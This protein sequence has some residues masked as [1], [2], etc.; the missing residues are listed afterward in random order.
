[1]DPTPTTTAEYED[2]SSL[3]AE[4]LDGETHTLDTA[5]GRIQKFN[6]NQTA[7]V[8]TFANVGE[9][10]D[11]LMAKN[12]KKIASIIDDHESLATPPRSPILSKTN[13]Q[14]VV[15]EVL[16]NATI[17]DQFVNEYLNNPTPPVSWSAIPATNQTVVEYGTPTASVDIVELIENLYLSKK[18][19]ISSLNQ[20][21]QKVVYAERKR[22][23]AAEKAATRGVTAPGAP[24]WSPSILQETH[25]DINIPQI[26][27][28]LNFAKSNKRSGSAYSFDKK[29]FPVR[30][31]KDV[32]TGAEKYF[33]CIQDENGVVSE[34]EHPNPTTL[35][36]DIMNQTKKV[37]EKKDVAEAVDM[38]KEFDK[39]KFLSLCGAVS[40]SKELRWEYVLNGQKF[41]IKDIGDKSA[42][43]PE[44]KYQVEFPWEEHGHTKKLDAKGSAEE[45]MKEISENIHIHTEWDH[46]FSKIGFVA[47]MHH[48]DK[49]SKN[50]PKEFDVGGK[51]IKVWKDKGVKMFTD[52]TSKE[53]HWYNPFSWKIPFSRPKLIPYGTKY[54]AEIPLPNGSTKTISDSTAESL[55]KQLSKKALSHESPESKPETKEAGGEKKWEKEDKKEKTENPE[56]PHSKFDNIV[57]KLGHGGLAGLIGGAIIGTKNLIPSWI[58][59]TVKWTAKSAIAGGVGGAAVAGGLMGASA[60][61]ITSLGTAAASSFFWPA[62]LTIGGV[63]AATKLYRT[64]RG[65]KGDAGHAP[66]GH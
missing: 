32:G 55:Y 12:G 49:H 40:K 1:M 4:H 45:V 7:V 17:R 31:E 3:L 61:G 21:A 42:T 41:L 62:A 58:R 29:W 36:R 20:V 18:I 27:A 15:Q 11:S 52:P 33:A 66:G 30:Y 25:E 22:E 37:K 28:A 64:W 65:K 26:Q 19:S 59:N 43:P 63:T 44:Q 35:I 5:T 14:E 23:K 24:E 8:K 48:L 53:A 2:I 38:G 10:I 56:H 9:F 60:L 47:F 34:L 6:K 16:T 50:H 57:H 51:K 46:A 13:F 54:Y 39:S